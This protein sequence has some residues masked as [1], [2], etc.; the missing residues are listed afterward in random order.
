MAVMSLGCKHYEVLSARLYAPNGN[1]S[2][3]KAKVLFKIK[4]NKSETLQLVIANETDDAKQYS[5]KVKTPDILSATYSVD[6]ANCYI[7]S[8]DKSDLTIEPKSSATLEIKIKRSEQKE[9]GNY[10]AWVSIAELTSSNLKNELA[11]RL[12]LNNGIKN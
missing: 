11:V 1:Y 7:I 5:V 12:L 6:C 2:I 3:D 8:I 4:P 10:E 9:I